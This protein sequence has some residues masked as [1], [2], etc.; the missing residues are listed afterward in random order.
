MADFEVSSSDSDDEEYVPE[1][2]RLLMYATVAVG[3][4]PLKLQLGVRACLQ[5]Q[6]A[7]A[8]SRLS[9]PFR[10]QANWVPIPDI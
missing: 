4:K 3:S 9:F 10:A 6:H 5:E 8:L 7:S 1:G 2:L